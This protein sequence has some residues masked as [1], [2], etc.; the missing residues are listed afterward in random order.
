M[1]LD[2]SLV[3][4]SLESFTHLSEENPSPLGASYSFFLT[5]CFLSPEEM[6]SD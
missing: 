6:F 3:V 4:A 2:I 1:L 5:E